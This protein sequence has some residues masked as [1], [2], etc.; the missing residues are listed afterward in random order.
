MVS[1]LRRPIPAEHLNKQ[2][3]S[4]IK[5]SEGH[6]LLFLVTIFIMDN[7]T[8]LFKHLVVQLC[9]VSGKNVPVDNSVI[10]R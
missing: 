2:Q 9:T 1:I 10:I 5:L 8:C 3:F 4:W 6:I 7:I